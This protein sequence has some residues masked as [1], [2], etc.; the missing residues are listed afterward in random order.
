MQTNL[1]LHLNVLNIGSLA[2]KLKLGL[3]PSIPS[4]QQI[5]SSMGSTVSPLYGL[6]RSPSRNQ[7][8]RILE[9]KWSFSAILIC[10][11]CWRISLNLALNGA[12]H[13]CNNFLTNLKSNLAHIFAADPWSM[14]SIKLI[15][16][17]KF[18]NWG[19]NGQRCWSHALAVATHSLGLVFNVTLSVN[20]TNEFNASFVY[21]WKH[22]GRPSICN[23]DILQK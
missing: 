13:A 15:E 9:Q 5:Y 3:N 18:W 23:P 11:I 2:R 19:G 6:E 14:A 8:W 17:S 1:V 22:W 12:W 16:C 20:N 7:F 21:R 4:L 10:H